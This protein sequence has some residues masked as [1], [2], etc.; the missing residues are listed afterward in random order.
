MKV[1]TLRLAVLWAFCLRY[2][3]VPGV[4]MRGQAAVVAVLPELRAALRDA[5]VDVRITAA[6]ALG[7]F[8]AEADLKEVLPLLAE[9]PDWSRHSV[10][11][12]LAALNSI[13]ALGAKAFP[14]AATIKTMPTNGPAHNARFKSYVPRPVGDLQDR[15]K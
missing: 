13:D 8:G 2:W 12:A 3:A 15:F 9:Q 7:Q 10:F 6:H 11:S 1:Y 5:S 14:L 4:L